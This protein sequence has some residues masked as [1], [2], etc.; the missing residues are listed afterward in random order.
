MGIEWAKGMARSD[1]DDDDDDDQS[2]FVQFFI[3]A[4]I[5]ESY[6]LAVSRAAPGSLHHDHV[7]AVQISKRHNCLEL[8]D[9]CTHKQQYTAKQY[10][11]IRRH[12]Y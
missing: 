8:D 9:A 1:D 6:Q 12:I 4:G 7:I 10:A 11:R 5:S 2:D 3:V